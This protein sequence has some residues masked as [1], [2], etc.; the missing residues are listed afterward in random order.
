MKYIDDEVKRNDLF[1]F[2]NDKLDNMLII[3]Y[4]PTI[5][6]VLMVAYG[7]KLISI[8][9]NGNFKITEKGE[10]FI[11]KIENEL[12]L[13]KDKYFLKKI[14]KKITEKKVSEYLKV[15]KND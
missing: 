1:K 15:I 12:I 7:E 2:I 4:D 9:N 10:Y 5:N 11:E 3:Q 13:Q 14:G 6:R 8:Q